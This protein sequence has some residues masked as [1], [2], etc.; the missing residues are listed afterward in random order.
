MGKLRPRERKGLTSNPA[1][2]QWLCGQKLRLLT[3]SQCW[4]LHSPWSDKCQP[5]TRWPPP[6]L[7]GAALL[8]ATLNLELPRTVLWAGRQAAS[9]S[10]LLCPCLGS[11]C[12]TD[13]LGIWN[14][15]AQV[16]ELLPSVDQGWR[17]S[18]GT[19]PAW[20][21]GVG[22]VEAGLGQGRGGTKGRRGGQGTCCHPPPGGGRML[23]ASCHLTA[24][25]LL[26]NM[27]G[28]SGG[29]DSA[30]PRL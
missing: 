2:N 19:E 1:V 7:L 6:V 11:R 25:A 26:W 4:G 18:L 14:F 29:R 3:P 21:V 24:L 27:A 30:W 13:L 9:F 15:G 12:D 20:T 23:S 28:D 8:Q 5:P 17:C 16:C 10:G 22:G